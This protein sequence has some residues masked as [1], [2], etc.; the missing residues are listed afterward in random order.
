VEAGASILYWVKMIE[1]VFNPSL[2]LPKQTCDMCAANGAI[3][4]TAYQNP[5]I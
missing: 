5:G 3:I 1:W 4:K 2:I